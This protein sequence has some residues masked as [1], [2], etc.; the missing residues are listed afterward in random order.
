MD[1]V[2]H[3]VLA[4]VGLEEPWGL[5]EAFAR[6]PRERP[7]DANRGADLI[8]ERLRRY[9]IPVTVHQPEIWLSLPI[10]AEVRAGGQ[11]FRA[12]PPAFAASRPEGVSA[13]LLHL[14][15]AGGGTPL[16][17]NPQAAGADVAGRVVVIEGFALPNFV[18]GLEAAGAAA[19]VAVN[20]GERIHWGTVS[21]IWGT[22]EPEDL[23]RLPEI[24]SAAVNQADG[25]AL[26]ALA[27]G[28]VEATVA[29]ELETGW[30]T[31]K[32]PVVE[33]EGASEPD[34]FVLLH[35]HYDSWREGVGD[36]GTGNAC[37]LEVARVLWA[38]RDR[39]R[40]SVRLAWWPGHST[41]RYAGS[42]WFADTFAL[43]LAEHCV[44]H[45]N[46]DSPG[47]RWAT[48]YQSISATAE[49]EG[50]LKAIVRVAT[51]QETAGKRPQ[52]NSDYTFNNIGISACFSASSMMP[53]EALEEHGY[54]LVGG[55]GGNIA[56]H[57]EDDTLEIADREVL[58]KDI[59]LYTTAVLHFA[60]AEI[61][62]IDWRAAAR[63]FGATV[64][65]YQEAAGGR[66]DLAPSRRALAGLST[67]LDDFYAAIEAGKVPAGAANAA[68]RDLAR[69]LIP[70][71]FTRGPR[72]QHDPALNV[73]PLPTIE[74]ALR[75]AQHDAATLGFARTQLVRGQN[76]LV[77]ALREASARIER[78]P[79]A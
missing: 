12:K 31:Q 49:C 51:G 57:T 47:C 20:P 27:A 24:P 77:A 30:F 13:P 39:L 42:A 32:L 8:V 33:I 40:R 23:A 65:R 79:P 62:P 34:A 25:Q 61:L 28:G 7:D 16:D 72:F 19:V 15:A 37:M 18:A 45:M 26:I 70:I 71:N 44:V 41:G 17:R 75:L 53:P 4:E 43:D 69:I 36:N 22:P 21:T 2:T 46:C 48:S 29:T 35:G 67:A 3:A 63:E 55:C 64:D 59:E 11:A 58:K 56:W 74:P 52:R 68:I 66:F 54:Y 6:Q 14:P 76:R 1:D 50:A 9:G 5:V 73:P 78:A 38:R 10:R 60:N